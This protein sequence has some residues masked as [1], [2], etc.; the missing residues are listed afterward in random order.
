MADG[1]VSSQ[2]YELDQFSTVAAAAAEIESHFKLRAV[3][4]SNEK[5]ATNTLTMCLAGLYLGVTPVLIEAQIGLD[6]K[7]SKVIVIIN[8]KSPSARLSSDVIEL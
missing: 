7:K 2:T 3:G 6:P 5:K 4:D 1:Q 8:G